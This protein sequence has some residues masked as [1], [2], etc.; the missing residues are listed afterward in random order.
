MFKRT[1]QLLALVIAL[2]ALGPSDVFAECYECILGGCAIAPPGRGFS[3]C[4]VSPIGNCVLTGHTCSP[5]HPQ[6][7]AADGSVIDENQVF[8]RHE[9]AKPGGFYL[10]AG[11]SAEIV[12]RNCQGMIV[13]RL[14]RPDL[15]VRI[16]GSAHRIIV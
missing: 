2:L 1:Y 16:R 15:S 14:M 6:N 5:F 3:G 8:A 11:L 12:R 13:S 7:V 10:F 9:A 4:Y